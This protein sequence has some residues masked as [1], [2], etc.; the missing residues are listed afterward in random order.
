ML[1]IPPDA[2][3]EFDLTKDIKVEVD[4]DKKRGLI[5]VYIEKEEK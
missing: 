2:V 3:K 5:M 1:P 4:T